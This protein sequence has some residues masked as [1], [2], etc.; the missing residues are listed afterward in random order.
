MLAEIAGTEAIREA[1]LDHA[2]SAELQRA[3]L[4]ITETDV[5]AERQRLSDRL[6]PGSSK[7]EAAELVRRVLEGRGLGP[8]RLGALLRRNAGMRKLIADE[9]VPSIELIELAHTIRFGKQLHTRMITTA[10]PHAAQQALQD[11]RSRAP[12]RGLMISFMEVAS[13][14]STDQSASLGG[15]LGPI[16]PDDPGLPVVIR[17][18]LAELEPMTISTILALDTGYAILLVEK[19]TPATSTTLDEVYESLEQEVRDRQERLLMDRLAQNLLREYSPSVLDASLRWS[20][21]R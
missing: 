18:T 1:V 21:E 6:M 11:I 19:T 3:G 16:S 10:T 17:S 15:D 8:V 5:D 12:E 9:A 7:E 14:R 2:V 4:A 13:E 20:W